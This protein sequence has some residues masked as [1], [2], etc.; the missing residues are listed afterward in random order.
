MT[1]SPDQNRVAYTGKD[2]GY[3]RNEQGH[4]LPTIG[5]PPIPVRKR[6]EMK[7]FVKEYIDQ[8]RMAVRRDPSLLTRD[9]KNVNRVFYILRGPMQTYGWEEEG[10]G[11]RKDGGKDRRKTVIEYIKDV[12]DELGI[13]RASIGI[14]TD[15]VGYLYYKGKQHSVGIDH[16][17]SLI[18]MGTDILIIEKQD[19]ALSLAPLAAPYRIG[20]LSTRGFLTEN[21]TD[22][23][24]LANGDGAHI[25]ILTDNDISGVV[26]A[27]KVPQVPRIGIDDQTLA[28]LNILQDKAKLEEEYSPNPTHLKH[29]QDNPGLFQDLNFDLEYLENKRIELNIVMEH[30]GNERFWEWVLTKLEELFPERDYTRVTE[31]PESYRYTPEELDNL[32]SRIK[33]HISN[34]MEP[35]IEDKRLG[36]VNYHGFIEDV[37]EY[38]YNMENEMQEYLDQNL[39]LDLLRQDLQQIIDR[40]DNG[41]YFQS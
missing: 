25:A 5:M 19:G 23:A 21:A 12:C 31:F 3:D 22:L 36:L 15:N 4:R 38:E 2:D 29:V 9:V 17:K 28:D 7:N 41:D 1:S 27:A 20:L 13:T 24:K 40:W 18:H 30:V 34:I 35:L 37:D 8:R 6:K 32:E 39:N 11:A 33:A 14:V 16:L 10:W 26:I